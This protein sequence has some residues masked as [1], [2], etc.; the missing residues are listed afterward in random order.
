MQVED[1]CIV[2]IVAMP[3]HHRHWPPTWAANAL[4][5][6]PNDSTAAS[7]FAA[8]HQSPC[9]TNRCC[10][11][12]SWCAPPLTGTLDTHCKQD[13]VVVDPFY[14]HMAPFF[15]LTF[16][17]LLDAKH[18]TAWLEFERGQ[19]DE[20][21]FAAIFFKDG[22]HV[23]P[24]ALRAAMTR[25][26]DFVP[27]MEP[28]LQELVDGGYQLHACSNY[29]TWYRAIEDKLALSRFL[30][31]TFVSCEGP[32]KVCTNKQCAEETFLCFDETT[33]ARCVSCVHRDCA[34]PRQSVSPWRPHTSTCPW[35]GCCWWMTERPTWRLRGRLGWM[36]CTF[37]TRSSC[38]GSW[39]RGGCWGTPVCRIQA[40]CEC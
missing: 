7:H 27:G 15:G 4:L 23:D 10:S 13:T 11:L 37:Q 14:K 31:W 28:L 36:R 17:E 25:A 5:G 8:L 39:W 16:Q 9:S 35:S 3:I 1:R 21:Q 40:L 12:T 30:E 33:I 18:P 2:D 6:P 38:G 29:T 34:N 26:Y 24:V 32:M 22:R 20:A 19:V